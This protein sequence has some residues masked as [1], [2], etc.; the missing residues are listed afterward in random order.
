[1]GSGF[2]QTTT[3][4][5]AAQKADRFF[6]RALSA[7]GRAD[8]Q[9]AIQ[10]L[11]AAL[12][13]CPGHLPALNELGAIQLGDGQPA[14]AL[15]TFQR[16]LPQ[17]AAG[18][19]AQLLNNIACCLIELGRPAEALPLL[20]EVVALQPSGS[21]TR[22]ITG[23]AQAL[24]NLAR[25][26]QEL[27][28][29]AVAV[30][31]ALAALELTPDD[32]NLRWL[33]A[34]LL[35]ASGRA[36]QAWPLFESRLF[37][38]N[39]ISLCAYPEQLVWSPQQQPPPCC[40]LVVG[41]Q[42]LG[43]CLMWLRFL[44]LLRPHCPELEFCCPAPLHAL[45]ESLQVVDR[46][47]TPEQLDQSQAERFL[48]LLS[49]GL[50]LPDL[51]SQAQACLTALAYQPPPPLLQRWAALRD[52]QPSGHLLV[53]LHWQGNPQAE[54]DSILRGRSIPLETL[55]P[56]RSLPG[57]QWVSLQYGHGVEQITDAD[58]AEWLV[59]WQGQVDD[60]PAIEERAA[61]LAA[62]DL[63]VTTDSMVAHLAGLVGTPTLLLLHHAPEWRWHP[64]A[65]PGLYPAHRQIQQQTPGD[66]APV[67]QQVAEAIHDRIAARGPSQ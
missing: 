49:L 16:A 60:A 44:P 56:L 36:G 5:R 52:Q 67:L 42:G 66:W 14:V 45:V 1:M 20:Q 48:P 58:R 61:L 35:L 32:H 33:A 46:C 25:V 23:R 27:K 47:L 12:A 28:E 31:A 2:G 39:A 3:P 59:P 34:N 29:L 43:D 53:G 17:A 41:E 13:A 6:E 57:C 19:R 54:Q 40:L 50:V 8:Q 65:I 21:S 37:A 62:C 9:G 4:Q 10:A 38:D 15:E 63:V 18:Q 51:L 26:G 22:D 64:D 24:V 55:R 11:R 7:L 30:E